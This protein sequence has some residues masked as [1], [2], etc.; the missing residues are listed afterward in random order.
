MIKASQFE[1]EEALVRC[2]LYILS[3]QVDSTSDLLHEGALIVKKAEQI[4]KFNWFE[5]Y[6]HG[7]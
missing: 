1:Q 5:L 2:A 4:R 6:I 7:Q 3:P